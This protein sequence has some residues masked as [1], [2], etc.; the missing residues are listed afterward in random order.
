MTSALRFVR[1]VIDLVLPPRCGGCGAIVDD[2][3]RFC[4]VC[5]QAIDF[6]DDGGC[7]QCSRPLD[8]R[9]GL[10][11]GTCLAAPPDFD[12]VI[13]GVAY[14]PVARRV[15]LRLKRGRRPGLA[16]TMAQVL[17][18][19]LADRAALLVPVPL[20][21]WRLWSRGFNQSVA[22]ASALSAR[23]RNPVRVNL[24]D[25]IKATRTMRGLNPT[26]RRNTVRGA[27]AVRG[28]IEGAHIYLVDDV[29]TTGATANACARALKKAGAARVTLI[30]WARVLAD[31]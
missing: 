31:H 11:C 25:R 24:L 6:L 28:R 5:W 7:A 16:R 27:F 3:H 4:A 17:A 1:P 22:I 8:G 9:E 26:Q 13:A 10:I 18:P 20:H 12:A 14:G 2:D 21:R 29:L 15:T 19:R 23:T 30:C